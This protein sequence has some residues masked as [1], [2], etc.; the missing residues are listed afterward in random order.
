MVLVVP[1]HFRGDADAL[2][3][4]LQVLHRPPWLSVPSGAKA[5]DFYKSAFEATEAYRHEGQGGGIVVKL[6]VSDAEFWLSAEPTDQ[7]SSIGEPIG[8]PSG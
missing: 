2:E 8:G 3:F 4:F 7:P 5:I 6:S 1:Y